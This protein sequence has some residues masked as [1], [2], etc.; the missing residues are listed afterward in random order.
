MIDNVLKGTTMQP[1]GTITVKDDFG[2]TV[3]KKPDGTEFVKDA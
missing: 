1:D 2:N 3:I